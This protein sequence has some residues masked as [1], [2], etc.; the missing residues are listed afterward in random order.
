MNPK[1]N[2][3]KKLIKL[4]KNPVKFILKNEFKKTSIT[5]IKNKNE[6]VY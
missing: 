4:G 3:K 6:P 1:I 5:L 2:G